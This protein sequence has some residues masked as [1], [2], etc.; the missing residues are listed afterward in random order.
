M[1]TSFGRE[2]IMKQAQDI[3]IEGFLVKPVTHSTLLDA[4]MM[5]FGREGCKSKYS[6]TEQAKDIE[7]LKEIH[8]ARILLA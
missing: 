3:E 5:A 2:E 6:R 1:V 4:T 7:A 8:G